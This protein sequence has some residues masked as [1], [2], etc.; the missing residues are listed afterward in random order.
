[1]AAAPSVTTI[2]DRELRDRGAEVAAGG[3]EPERPALLLLREEVGDVGHRTGEVAAAD[4]AEGGDEQ[5]HRERGLGVGHHDA[6]QR[7]GDEQEAGRDDRPVASA[8][9]RD[10]EGVG[11]PQRG[12]DEARHRDEPEQLGAGQVEARRGEHDDDDAPQLPD[13]EPEELG[14][15]RPAEVAAGDRASLGF[16]EPGVLGVPAVHPPAGAAGEGDAGCD[17]DGCRGIRRRRV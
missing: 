5:Q 16:P 13:D 14:E 7:G 11:E 4:A 2:G 15:D 6:E 3:V 9:D 8:E 1:M 17:G 10:H 12:A